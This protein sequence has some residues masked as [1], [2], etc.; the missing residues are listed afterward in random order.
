MW[1]SL[2]GARGDPVNPADEISRTAEFDYP[3]RIRG[4]STLLRVEGIAGP[5]ALVSEFL[6]ALDKVPEPDFPTFGIVGFGLVARLTVNY[7]HGVLV[8]VELTSKECGQ[9]EKIR[10]GILE[11]VQEFLK[12][13]KDLTF[14]Q[15]P[16]V[17]IL[18]PDRV[19][20]SRP[21]GMYY[22]DPDVAEAFTV[23]SEE[24]PVLVATGY[25]TRGQVPDTLF[26]SGVTLF[27]AWCGDREMREAMEETA[28]TIVENYGIGA[29]LS[30]SKVDVSA[31]RARNI[32]TL[33]RRLQEMASKSD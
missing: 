8:E 17:E 28:S 29:A 1:S 27:G 25:L 14:T 23:M 4:H 30:A 22:L 2:S 9:K 24:F 3:G 7:P 11:A 31:L 21:W 19:I 15:P 33:G 16:S 26:D 5:E 13:H 10:V 6:N 12:G 32:E 20:R 18:P